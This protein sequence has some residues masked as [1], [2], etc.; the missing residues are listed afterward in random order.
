MLLLTMVRDATADNG[1]FCCRCESSISVYR[2]LADVPGLL[3][4]EVERAERSLPEG[5][6][7]QGASRTPL[8]HDRGLLHRKVDPNTR[9][10][11]TKV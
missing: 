9:T 5:P 4:R 11:V 6:H 10:I 2:K 3:S 8:R 7:R 1:D